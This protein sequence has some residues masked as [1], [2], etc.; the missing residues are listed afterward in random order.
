MMIP[1]LIGSETQA[2]E[3]N[4]TLAELDQ[5]LSSDQVLAGIVKGLPSQVV[6]GV[7]RSLA[8]ERRELKS[9]LDAYDLAKKGDF[10]LLRKKAGNDLGAALIVARISRKLSQKDLARKLGLHEQAVQRY[11]AEKYRSISLA[12]YLKF[13]SVLGVEWRLSFSSA[14]LDGSA[15]AKD[16]SPLEAR[17]MLKHARS[18]GWFAKQN[19]SDEDGL[20]QL[21]R[22]IADH[23]VKYGTPSL[24]RTGLNVVDHS[25]DWS[26]LLW[27][28]QVVRRAEADIERKK[29][30]YRPLDVSWLL[31]LVR[32][33][34]RD[35]GPARA[36]DLLSDHG[37]IL[38]AEPHIAGMSVDGAAF[39]VGDV[40]VVGVTLLRDTLDN[41]WFTLLHEIAHII[42]HY[43]TGLVTGFFDD[44]QSPTLDELEQEANSFASNLLIPEEQ[45][46]RSPARIAKKAS[47]IEALARQLGIHPA[48]IFGR[49]RME[50][51]DYTIFSNR[52]GQGTVRKQFFEV[53]R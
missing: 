14:M 30:T 34:A 13:A 4:V 48:I 31:D 3:A 26:L 9:L 29:P 41:F 16:I 7:R 44:F 46:R 40:P 20:S 49:I 2:R 11:E 50:R 36:A 35:D 53:N 51:Q 10:E 42:L 43:R 39:L 32:L 24:L 17:K 6:D 1:T 25:D 8:A 15:L 5:A 45:W 27:K 52:I 22:Y 28:A 37:I 23:V 21:K 12:N 18:N 33:S 19:P 38:I 47:P